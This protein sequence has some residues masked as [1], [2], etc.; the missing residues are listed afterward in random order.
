MSSR[1]SEFETRLP[2]SN[3]NFREVASID[4]HIHSRQSL[5][6]DMAFSV[7]DGRLLGLIERRGPGDS[8]FRRDPTW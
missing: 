3:F 1:L 4:E 8:D 2:C 7:R 6:T 5:A